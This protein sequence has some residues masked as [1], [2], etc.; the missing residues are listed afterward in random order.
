MFTKFDI[1]ILGL[2]ATG[3]NNG[4]FIEGK[5]YNCVSEQVL[6]RVLEALEKAGDKTKTIYITNRIALMLFMDGDLTPHKLCG[7]EHLAK[8]VVVYMQFNSN[9]Y[10]VVIVDESDQ[11]FRRDIMHGLEIFAI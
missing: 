11:H 3:T 8:T 2:S 9:M 7:A 5:Q 4:L 10:R 6:L 1:T